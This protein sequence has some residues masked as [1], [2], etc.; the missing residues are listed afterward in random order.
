[1]Q[2]TLLPEHEPTSIYF[3]K[4]RRE[5]DQLPQQPTYAHLRFTNRYVAVPSW[6]VNIQNQ[7]APGAVDGPLLA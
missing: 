3:T 2:H 4:Q 6:H 1:M 5:A 7:A